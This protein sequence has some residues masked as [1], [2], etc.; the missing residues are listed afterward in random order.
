MAA[1]LATTE[2]I[3]RI[4]S[5]GQVYEQVYLPT[6]S[7]A[8]LDGVQKG[9]E[10]SLLQIYS[11]SLELL[12]KS[13]TLFSSNTP[14][15]TLQAIINP[16]KM[17]ESLS[18]FGE[19]EDELLRDVQACEIKRGAAAD[20]RMIGMLQALDAPIARMDHGIG[21]LLEHTE[22]ST[23]ISMLE[24]ISSVPF[25]KHH[26]TVREERTPGTG[27]WLLQLE[28]FQD[29]EANKSS[30]LF[31]LQGSPGTG[32]THLTSTVIDHI[33]SQLSNPLTD[34]GFAFFYCDRDEGT[35]SQPL[36]ILQSLVRQLSTATS[37]PSSMQTKLLNACKEA[38]SK[39]TNF[40][41]N[42]CE[43]QILASM[44]IYQQTTL[45]IDAMDECDSD[46]RDQFLDVL[47]SFM[48]KAKRPLRIFISSRPDSDIESQLENTPSMNISASDNRDD[49]KKYLQAELD[50]FARKNHVLKPLKT[51]IVDK[52]LERSQGM[53]QWAFF[54]VH[55]IAKCGSE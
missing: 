34:E 42:Q 16:G 55:Q 50:R 29:W 6:V 1:L 37:N 3:V 17:S 2:R 9:L 46:S 53:F 31:W 43:D 10:T 26:D 49:I 54:Q 41:L 11:T 48:S 4:T 14:K 52:L 7:D 36:S 25:G 40:R 47:N 19:K 24:W 12:A 39:G 38:R 13:G 35:R 5:R 22:E 44:D 8:D 23:R 15:R 18:G 28:G 51:N 32:K 45:V 33:R 20:D 30:S 27:E 21:H